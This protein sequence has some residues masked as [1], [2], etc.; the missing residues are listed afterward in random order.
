MERERGRERGER[1]R[2]EIS[3]S[4]IL[5]LVMACSTTAMQTI[6]KSMQPS[7]EISVLRPNC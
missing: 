2:E 7:E 3:L 4:A 1:A 6:Y 5:S